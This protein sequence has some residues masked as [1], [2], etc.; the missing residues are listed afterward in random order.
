METSFDKQIGKK[1]DT[2]DFFYRL[3]VHGFCPPGEKTMIPIIYSWWRITVF[4]NRIIM[5]L[6]LEKI[7]SNLPKQS[8]WLKSMLTAVKIFSFW[9][10]KVI[11][12]KI[13]IIWRFFSIFSLMFPIS[14]C[15]G[16]YNKKDRPL[17]LFGSWKQRFSK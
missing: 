11:P 1:K 4:V 15:F 2:F 14:V 16:R 13:N 6:C 9:P 10:I 17:F 3:N 5:R 8:H 7:K 12:K